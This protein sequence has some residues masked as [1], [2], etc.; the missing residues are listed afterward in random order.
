[1][2]AD[3]YSL[4]EGK[5]KRTVQLDFSDS[6]AISPV[7]RISACP[8][9]K[10]F[11][12]LTDHLFVGQNSLKLLLQDG[13]N[14]CE[15]SMGTSSIALYTS[16]PK[17]Y[18]LFNLSNLQKTYTCSI[19]ADEIIIFCQRFDRADKA[20]KSNSV[21]DLK[22]P[23]KINLMVSIDVR[24]SLLNT[25]L[26]SQHLESTANIL[27]IAERGNEAEICEILRALDSF[28]AKT[29]LDK[30]KMAH[31]IPQ[32]NHTKTESQPSLFGLQILGLSLGFAGRAYKKLP[33]CAT[34]FNLIFAWQ[35]LLPIKPQEPLDFLGDD[36]VRK[37]VTKWQGWDEYSIIK[38]ALI[39]NCLP[40]GDDDL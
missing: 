40:L 13:K 12:V 17:E 23:E 26:N 34:I 20:I 32:S 7:R 24:T 39:H 30:K 22:E 33:E 5:I 14:V 15:I 11:A 2:V 18:L 1:M 28:L 9:G 37:L 8:D 27:K 19:D 16:Q 3:L 21:R 35:E 25:A 29:L 36:L 31:K 10:V 4:F 38:D 6:F